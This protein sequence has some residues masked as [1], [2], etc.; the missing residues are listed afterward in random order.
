MD[1]TAP[2]I[3]NIIRD[4]Y[5]YYHPGGYTTLAI[6][7]IVSVFSS[8][9]LLFLF[10]FVVDCISYDKLFHL[11]SNNITHISEII[12]ITTW[13]PTNTYLIICFA[14]YSMYLAVITYRCISSLR[15]YKIIRAIYQEK[16]EIPDEEIDDYTWEQVVDRL[17]SLNPADN[18]ITIF[19]MNAAVSDRKSTRLN[20]SHEWISRMP[21][22]A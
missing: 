13:F 18:Q 4:I 15:Y 8:Y 1:T 17:H 14:F 7:S 5:H 6:H 12:T 16:L 10:Y 20:S 11:S 19:N 9:L 3:K 22:S 2:A 21:C